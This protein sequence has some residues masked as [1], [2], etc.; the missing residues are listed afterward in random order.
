MKA[1]GYKCELVTEYAKELVYARDIDGLTDQKH[2]SK[3]QAHRQG[4]LR[5]KV[6]Y[7][8][9]DSPL[10]LGLYYARYSRRE[11]EGL[12]DLIWSEWQRYDNINIFV[13]RVKPYVTYG[14][15]GSEDSAREVCKTLRAML[16]ELGIEYFDVDGDE[17]APHYVL[18]YI[19]RM[20]AK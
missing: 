9:T 19:K 2:V 7:I 13:N 18:S 20:E 15:R 16:E 11:T 8:I 3:V 1:A 17:A 4:I 12:G 5:G 14:R 6:D 10:P